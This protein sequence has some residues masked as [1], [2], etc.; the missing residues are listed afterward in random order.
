MGKCETF[1]LV[2]FYLDSDMKLYVNFVRKICFKL[3]SILRSKKK[4]I[5]VFPF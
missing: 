5:G 4:L 3:L 2:S 1:N